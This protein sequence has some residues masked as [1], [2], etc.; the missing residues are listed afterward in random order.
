M[1]VQETT[2]GPAAVGAQ[3]LKEIIVSVEAAG[4]IECLRRSGELNTVHI[5]AAIPTDADA[6]WQFALV[7][8]LADESDTAQFRHQRRIERNL[9]YAG[10]NLVLRF[11]H[12]LALHRIDL[13][14]Q[15]VLGLSGAN[16]RVERRIAYVASVP[17]GLTFDL[18]SAEQVREAG[19]SDNHV[20]GH[21]LAPEHVEPS[22]LHIGGGNE[23]LQILARAHGVEIDETLDQIL[24]RIDI[25]RIE[26]VWRQI[27]RERLHPEADRRILDRPKRKQAIDRAPLNIG[28]ISA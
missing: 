14:K 8:Q 24:Q 1:R 17:I 13:N 20:R 21:L 2:S 25:E 26:I 23:Q 18:N 19:R 15:Q 16:Q 27:S 5:D 9:V 6:A 11:R 12:L 10:H 22:G 28:Q 7:D 4:G 3:H